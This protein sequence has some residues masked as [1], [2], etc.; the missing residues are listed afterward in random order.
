MPKYKKGELQL[1][2][3]Q[4]LSSFDIQI[5]ASNGEKATAESNEYSD[6]VQGSETTS[7]KIS[8]FFF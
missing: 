5:I 4:S 8:W 2:K 6:P 1:K 3:K 7:E